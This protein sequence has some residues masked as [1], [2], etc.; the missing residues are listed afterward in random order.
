M[1]LGGA[2]AIPFCLSGAVA[3]VGV[4]VLGAVPVAFLAGLAHGAGDDSPGGPPA[5]PPVRTDRERCD[6]FAL[7]VEDLVAEGQTREIAEEIAAQ[8]FSDGSGVDCLTHTIA[9]YYCVNGQINRVLR[10]VNSLCLE[11]FGGSSG[12]TPLVCPPGWAAPD[13]C[14]LMVCPAPKVPMLETPI[15]WACAGLPSSVDCVWLFPTSTT[16]SW[17]PCSG[18]PGTGILNCDCFP[19]LLED[20][21]SLTVACRNPAS[22]RNSEGECPDCSD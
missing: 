9:V 1:R 21:T 16:P 15:N 6:P 20:C 13:P 3:A 11:S 12:C 2:S 22:P 14:P 4:A 5:D 18:V 17:T 19:G 7:R 8:E 10:R